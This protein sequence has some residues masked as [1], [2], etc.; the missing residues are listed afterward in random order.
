[1]NDLLHKATD[2]T[3]ALGKVERTELSSTDTVVGVG[4]EDTSGFTLVAN[5]CCVEYKQSMVSSSA[6]HIAAST[7]AARD[8][9]TRPAEAE[10]SACFEV[11]EQRRF[12]P[13]FTH[14]V[15]S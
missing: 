10:P 12:G 1:M 11:T 2:V 7:F 4:L 9:E 15:P 5:D 3:V 8:L 14:H 13:N 6:L